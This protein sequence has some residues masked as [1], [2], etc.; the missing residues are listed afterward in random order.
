MMMNRFL[1]ALLA[2]ACLPSHA[3]AQSANGANA[4][5]GY[6]PL[7]APCAIAGDGKC[8]AIGWANGLP[9]TRQRPPRPRASR[10]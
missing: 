5:G 8:Y 7:S 10:P 3:Q 2:L 9:V 6:A 4:P 1:A